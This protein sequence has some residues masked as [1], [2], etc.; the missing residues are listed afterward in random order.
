ME[1]HRKFTIKTECCILV[2]DVE[3]QAYNMPGI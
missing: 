3:N 1:I 2:E